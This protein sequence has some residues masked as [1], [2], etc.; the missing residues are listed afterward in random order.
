MS[1]SESDYLLGIGDFSRFTR[2]SV[3]M[4]RHYD[5]RGLLRPAV[6]DPY[7]GYRFYAP[8]QLKTAGRIRA[9][10]DA[11]CGIAQ[12][13][14]LLPLFDDAD[15]LG[16]ALAEHAQSLEAAARQIADQQALLDHILLIAKEAPM[17]ITVETRTIPA[18]R[19]LQLRRT[20]PTYNHEG[21]LWAEFGQFLQAPGTPP[22]SQFGPLWGAT[23]FDPDYREADADVAIWAEVRGEV[24]PPAGF[25]L[26]DR[27]AQEVAWATLYGA[28]DGVSAVSEAIGAWIADHGK[29]PA[30][31]MFNVFIVSP[32]Q[33]PDPAN[34]VTE[35]NCPIA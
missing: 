26:V 4:L 9:L 32:S 25:A 8:A 30:G 31:P 11:G 22:M 35:V 21:E 13:A 24:T 14:D 20:I 23:Y 2:L 29:T 16:A 5:E 34:W 27:P 28:Y 18:H 10:R 15:R 1:T 7:N 17:S 33:D 3:R 6:I 12:I 19:A